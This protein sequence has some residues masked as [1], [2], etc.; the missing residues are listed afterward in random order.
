MNTA[1]TSSRSR[2]STN[3]A[4]ARSRNASCAD[5]DKCRASPTSSLT[6]CSTIQNPYR[7]GSISPTDPYGSPQPLT[8][9]LANPDGYAAHLERRW[10]QETEE[11]RRDA[12]RKQAQQRREAAR[13]QAQEQREAA[14]RAVERGERPDLDRIWAN[15]KIGPDGS[16]TFPD[17]DQATDPQPPTAPAPPTP[18]PPA[19]RRR[20]FRP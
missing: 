2:P 16:V 3:A 6:R 17:L 7:F 12:E 18:A 8:Q 14:R 19:P 11:R 10:A 5:G 15:R 13:R 1:A 4:T 20:F 9:V